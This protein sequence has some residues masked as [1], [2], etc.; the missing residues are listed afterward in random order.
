ML[1]PKYIPLV[2]KQIVRHPIRSLLTVAGV[3]VAMF[4]F[5][6]VQAMHQGVTEATEQS[7]GDTELIVYRE[8]RYC[9]MSSNLP[10]IYRDDIVAIPGVVSVVPMRIVPT[11]CRTSLDVI[12][13][14]GVMESQLPALAEPFDIL[15][16]S[17]S[18][19][20]G[21]SDGAMISDAMARR[22]GLSVGD[23]FNAAG[24]RGVYVAGIF[25]SPKP[26]DYNVAYV[27]LPFLQ[28][29]SGN[30]REG[31]VTQFNVKVASGDLL[32][33]IAKKIDAMFASDQAPTTTSPQKA[34]VA[35]AAK[36]V[37]GIVNF[38]RYLGYASLAAILALV[39]N[40]IVLSCQDRLRDH[41]ILQTLGYNGGLIARM[42]LF[43]GLLLGLTGG[44]LGAIGAWALHQFGSISLSTEGVTIAMKT[45]WSVAITG[46]TLSIAM[47]VLAGLVPAFQASRRDIVSCFRTV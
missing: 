22:R 13:F 38:A 45:T 42:I 25:S 34:F 43:E 36:N 33:P 19:W 32:E 4:L 9:P 3:A 37:L 1:S 7:A 46:L 39:G 15:S 10:Q 2:V 14:R 29:N 17:V 47:G 21:R 30:R 5:C 24:V 41:A 35:R 18:E 40:A 23:S 27:H 11:N 28:R 8:N 44:V 6:A 20:T 31:T 26:E 16:G 12:T